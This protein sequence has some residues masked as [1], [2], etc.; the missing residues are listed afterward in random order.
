MPLR[1]EQIERLRSRLR[2]RVRRLSTRANRWADRLV[3]DSMKSSEHAR[4]TIQSAFDACAIA[5][6]VALAWWWIAGLHIDALGSLA[7][8]AAATL[9]AS[10]V[11]DFGTGFAHWAA[12]TWGSERVPIIGS[13]FIGP[14]REHHIDPK[15]ITR[16]DF[17]ETNGASASVV[18]PLLFVAGLLAREHGDGYLFWSTLLGMASL[19]TLAT[20]QVHKWAHAD[21]APR[22]V[23]VLQRL[24]IVLSP[25]AHAVHHVAPHERHYCITHGWLNPVLDGIGFY[26]GLERLIV[27]VFGAVPRREDLGNLA[28]GRR[29]YGPLLA[30]PLPRTRRS[31]PRAGARATGRPAAP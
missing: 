23:Q 25:E 22:P 24:G 7:I 6:F 31:M 14:F 4:P 28:T 8:A 2:V 27:K 9:A 16:H 26:R 20:N 30:E 15:A 29:A 19:L 21:V 1:P 10:V 12:D 17:L 13:T 5:T 18:L 3:S 11:T